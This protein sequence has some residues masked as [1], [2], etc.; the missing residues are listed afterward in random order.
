MLLLLTY[1]TKDDGS[2]ELIPVGTQCTPTCSK[3][4]TSNG[5]ITC[6]KGG[7]VQNSFSCVGK[8]CNSASVDTSSIMGSKG[9]TCAGIVKN[10]ESCHLECER[11]RDSF[12][13]F[14]CKLGSFT[15]LGTPA[16]EAHCSMPDLPTGALA[17]PACARDGDQKSYNMFSSVHGPLGAKRIFSEAR[18]RNGKFTRNG[19]VCYPL[20]LHLP[21]GA[22]GL[23]DCLVK[24]SD[25]WRVYTHDQ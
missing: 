17:G 9:L 13:S 21:D 10:E 11:G 6:E 25:A 15:S 16:C 23:G 12:G 5:N 7:T 14:V 8:P 20:Q 22:D 1:P 24:N 2:V 19:V 3:H 18:L 4:Y